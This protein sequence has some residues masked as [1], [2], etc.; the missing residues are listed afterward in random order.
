M[1]PFVALSAVAV[2]LGIINC[3]TDKILPA[4]YLKKPRH[5]GYGQFLFHDLRFDPD[6]HPRPD[7]ILN[8]PDF[9]G[10]GILVAN[11]NFG[12]GSSREGAVYAL[13][14]FGFRAVIAP[15]FGDIFFNNCFKNGVLPIA[16]KADAV[17]RMR[18]QLAEAPGTSMHIDLPGQVVIGPDGTPHKFA[19]NPLRKRCLIEG[20][21]DVQLTLKFSDAIAA[22][23]CR[24]DRDLPW[25]A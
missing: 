12:C 25:L 4:R 6:G 2:P 16:L 3:D 14:D 21:D 18:R 8:R 17:A 19:V 9:A 15:S 13:L 22:F 11:A 7:F 1:I 10:G 5:G 23:E 20:L 24:R